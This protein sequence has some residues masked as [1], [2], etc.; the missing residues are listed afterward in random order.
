M[1]RGSAFRAIR[2]WRL[3]SNPHGGNDD[4][5]PHTIQDFAETMSLAEGW[6]NAPFQWCMRSSQ[7][8]E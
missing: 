6:L 5:D 8:V 2:R 3:I 7:S 4:L 1:N